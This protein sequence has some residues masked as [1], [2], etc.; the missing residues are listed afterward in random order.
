MSD[1]SDLIVP[2]GALITCPSCSAKIA[3]A[4]VDIR[5]SSPLSDDLFIW[6]PG[7][8]PGLGDAIGCRACNAAW[9]ENLGTPQVRIHTSE[10][11]KP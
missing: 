8:D 9:L 2:S 7:F 4:N 1:L 11:W 6:E 10:G 5:Y 3:R